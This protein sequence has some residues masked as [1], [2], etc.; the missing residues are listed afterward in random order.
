MSH[1]DPANHASSLNYSETNPVDGSTASASSPAGPMPG[2]NKYPRTKGGNAKLA[3]ALSA[4]VYD[5][6]AGATNRESAVA[7]SLLQSDV[8]KKWELDASQPNMRASLCRI[9]ILAAGGVTGG[10]TKDLYLPEGKKTKVNKVLECAV[11]RC[12]TISIITDIRLHNLTRLPAGITTEELS[13]IRKVTHDEAQSFPTKKKYKKRVSG[14]PDKDK[15]AF[16]GA[17]RFQ[18]RSLNPESK[19]Y[20]LREEAGMFLSKALRAIKEAAS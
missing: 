18:K 20:S 10:L 1:I 5:L 19:F 12:A 17:N 8:F 7:Q 9:L 13:H 11:V 6:M 16:S 3:L 2:P 4:L 14:K 15:V